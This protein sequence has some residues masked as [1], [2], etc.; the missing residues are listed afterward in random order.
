MRTREDKVINAVLYPLMVLFI[1]SIL[2]P[3][4]TMLVDSFSTV[5]DV[6]RPGFH[7]YTTQFTLE[8]YAEVFN[9]KNI[10]VAY[11]N[12]IFRATAGTF[13]CVLVCFL[14]A[15]PL[16]RK[17]LPFRRTITM[18]IIFTMFFSGGLIPTY[19]VIRNLHLLDTHLVLILPLLFNGFYILVMRN[20]LYSIPD[21]LEE[22]A[23]I[24][25]ANEMN[26][27]FRIFLPLSIPVIATITLFASVMF[28]N[29]WFQAMIYTRDHSKMVMQ[30]LLRRILLENQLNALM[31]FGEPDAFSSLTEESVRAALIFIAIGPIVLIYPFVQK[32]FITGIMAGAVKG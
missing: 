24:D 32:Y 9:Q 4:W 5:D 23:L 15:Y 22:S 27:C 25:G 1:I 12:T 14:A 26:I 16:S 11:L 20:F 7:L 19:I 10:G 21:D 30:L 18:L 29:E 3:F 2:L 8:A 6:R 17:K 13:L 28:W 31:E